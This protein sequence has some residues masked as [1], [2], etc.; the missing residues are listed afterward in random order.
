MQIEGQR[1]GGTDAYA[2]LCC[3]TC[4]ATWFEARQGR[5]CPKCLK[6]PVK[7]VKNNG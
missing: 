4:G 1:L 2:L 7:E 6:K 5:F 3:R